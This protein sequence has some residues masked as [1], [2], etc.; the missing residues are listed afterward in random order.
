MSEPKIARKS[1]YDVELEA[2]KRYLWC[3]CGYSTTQPFCDDESHKP[4]GMS[5]VSFKAQETKTYWLCA[6]KRSKDKPFCDGTHG[7]L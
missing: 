3:A 5:P 4:H 6:C 1:P 7:K 2:G